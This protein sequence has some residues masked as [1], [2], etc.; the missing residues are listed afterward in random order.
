VSD[1]VERLRAY[2]KDQGGWLNI[3]DTCEEAADEIE[4]LRAGGCARNQ[5]T[6]QFCAEAS[7]AIARAKA[8]EARAVE[9]ERQLAAARGALSGLLQCPA[10]ADG[11]H[12]EPAWYCEETATAERRARAALS[13]APAPVSG[14][15][16]LRRQLA[17]ANHR[18]ARCLHETAAAL[19]PDYSFTIDGLPKAAHH[20]AG[21]LAAAREALAK[22]A[23]MNELGVTNYDR[24]RQ[25][26][27]FQAIARAALEEK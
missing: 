11:N 23:G 27:Y 26:W 14:E 13:D 2:A 12:T 20:V 10:I 18:Q 15:D 24:G 22:I 19:G 5:R 7:D 21:Q 6:T 17:E 9:A 8:A 25:Q 4:R 3:D 16:D 1:I